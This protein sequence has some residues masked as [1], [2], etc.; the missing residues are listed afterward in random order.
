MSDFDQL[1]TYYVTCDMTCDIVHT[2]T[3]TISNAR[4]E[5]VM[6][7]VNASFWSTYYILCD[8]WHKLIQ[9]T[10]TISHVRYEWVMSHMTASFWSTY[11][12]RCVTTLHTTRLVVGLWQSMSRVYTHDSLCNNC[13]YMTH[14]YTHDST[15]CYITLSIWRGC[16]WM[17][18]SRHA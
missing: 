10:I 15:G 12:A 6:S 1:V 16:S 11:G 2:T 8:L 5:W 13:T 7:H 4:Y 17:D 18:E 14:V 9:R 3:I